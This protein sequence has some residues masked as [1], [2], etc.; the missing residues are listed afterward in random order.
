M[1][2]ADR[3]IIDGMSLTKPASLSGLAKESL[4]ARIITGE[5]SAGKI[6]SVPSLAAAFGVSATPVR[7]ALVE[8]AS[9]G[10]VEVVPNQ[11]F[12]VVELSEEDL[13][14]IFQVRLMLEVP[15]LVEVARLSLGPDELAEFVGLAQDIERFAAQGDTVG[16]LGADR[17]FH[18]GLL[19]KLGNGRLVAI[20]TQLRDQAR[21]YGLRLLIERGELMDSAHEH[22]KLVEAILRRDL[23]AV[24]TMSRYHMEHTRGIWAHANEGA[25]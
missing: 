14:H 4:R 17:A 25:R 13:D 7:E 3:V 20:V 21:L 22:S 16:Y 5:I 11:G 1:D 9:D 15:G 10:L 19:S 6:Y 2:G 12:R 23:K 24:R 8:L 18:L